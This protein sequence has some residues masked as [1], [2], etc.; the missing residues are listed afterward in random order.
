MRAVVNAGRAP[1]AVVPA[2][3]EAARFHT[4]LPG[5]RP[6]P[7]RELGA[8]A[9]ELGLHAV[10]LKD[11]SDRLGLPAFK[12]LGASWAIARALADRSGVTT[13]VAAS[14]GNHGRAVAHEAARRGLACR[15]F[16]PARSHR[17]FGVVALLVSLV[18]VTAVLMP[19]LL[20]GAA[21]RAG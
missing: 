4:A 17:F 20:F 16:L 15:V 1:A 21:F 3:L 7:L 13:L 19:V 5:Y 8:V 18:L 10:T 6:T 14:A 2:T 12:I 11:E 9:A